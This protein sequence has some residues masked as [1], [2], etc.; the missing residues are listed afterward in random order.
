MAESYNVDQMIGKLA[1]INSER[2]ESRVQVARL[3]NLQVYLTELSLRKH[4]QGNEYSEGSRERH[5]L[6]SQS[7]AYANVAMWMDDILKG[8]EAKLPPIF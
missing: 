5:G 3:R 1:Q 2:N 4:N 6:K 8:F 7:H